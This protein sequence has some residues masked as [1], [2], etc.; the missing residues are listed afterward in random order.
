MSDLASRL[1]LS[2]YES[3]LSIGGSV[4]IESNLIAHQHSKQT[5]AQPISARCLPATQ[6]GLLIST[7][8]TLTIF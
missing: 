8:N 4:S 7:A 3:S 2:A 1:F 6:Q 5:V